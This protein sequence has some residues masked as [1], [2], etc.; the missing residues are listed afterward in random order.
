MKAHKVSKSQMCVFLLTQ[1]VAAFHVASAQADNIGFIDVF[2]SEKDVKLWHF[3]DN[4]VVFFQNILNY[5][6]VRIKPKIKMHHERN[7]ILSDNND[8]RKGVK[9]SV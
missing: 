5:R 2:F 9:L 7:L 3:K 4:V 1:L 6:D 8:T